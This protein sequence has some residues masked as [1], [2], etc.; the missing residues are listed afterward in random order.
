MKNNI[1]ISIGTD[2]GGQGGVSTVLQ[3]YKECGFFD[4][5]NVV[6]IATHVKGNGAIKLLRYL[7]SL[8]KLTFLS[9][10]NNV[11][12]YHIH[13]SSKA[14]YYR[15]SLLVRLIK[16]LGGKVIL[17]LHGAEFREFYARE[18]DRNRKKHLDA[19]FEMSDVVIV[20]SSQWIEWA[21]STFN[22]TEHFKLLYNA[23]PSVEQTTIRSPSPTI[24]FLGRVGHRKGV[25]DLFR[26]LV[27][28]KEQCPDV[29]LLIG[30]DGD[31][32][33][34]RAITKDFGIECYVEFLG[35]VSGQRK[36][37]LLSQSHIYCLPSYNEGFPMGVLEAMS[38]G[39]AVVS[40]YAGGIPDA[41]H[42]GKE[43]F[44]V[45]PG[46][47][48]ALADALIRLLTEPETSRTFTDNA[49]SKFDA[50]FS[51]DA[52]IPQLQAIYDELQDERCC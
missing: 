17:H 6:H 36:S 31:I 44:L 35:W 20:L 40:T 41:I 14:S 27:K 9:V 4:S 24:C 29:R 11:G 16:F 39:T 32:E 26:A 46:D 28:V 18:C 30:G 12:V 50:R 34:Y 37:D 7:S 21:K 51:V 23:V 52:I 13:M 10:T 38:A 43:G 8:F 47:S 25:N 15:K 45:E 42:S 5:N 3:T 22:R 49:K 48:D 19:T 1:N 33:K 2:I